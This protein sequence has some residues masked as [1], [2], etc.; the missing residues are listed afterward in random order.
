MITFEMLDRVADSV[1][2]VF[3]ILVLAWAW[4]VRGRSR[5]GGLFGNVCTLVSVAA[6]YA[7]Q[8]IDNR[9][10]IW[11]SAG[12]EYSTHTAVCTAL[13]VSLFWMDRR[14]GIAGIVLGVLYAA[15]MRYQ[16]YHAVGDIISTAAVLVA[17]SMACWW[18]G[19]KLLPRAK[20]AASA[21]S[22]AV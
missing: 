10:H 7:L 22:D 12:L 16:N 6:V 2:P 14:A 4:V 15:L 1:N 19:S 11:S 3:G 8:W 18:I 9:L 21:S 5:H 13:I 20:T 17:I